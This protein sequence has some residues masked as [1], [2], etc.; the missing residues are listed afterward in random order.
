LIGQ[1]AAATSL[2]LALGLVPLLC[3]VIAAGSLRVTAMH[4]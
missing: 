3:A 4:G 2:P 1:L